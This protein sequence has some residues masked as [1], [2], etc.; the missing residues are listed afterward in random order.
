ML[1]DNNRSLSDVT[2]DTVKYPANHYTS[3]I[4]QKYVGPSESGYCGWSSP[5]GYKC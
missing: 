4:F 2:E 1:H 5:I 3:R